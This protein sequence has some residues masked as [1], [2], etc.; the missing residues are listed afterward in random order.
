MPPLSSHNRF[1]TLSVDNIPKIDEPVADPQAVQ[2]L[3]KTPVR[4]P[5]RRPWWERRL[6]AHFIVDELDET[7]GPRRSLKLNIE[8]QTTDT[9]ETR[10]VKALLDSGATGMFIDR[11]YVK[12]NC[13]PTWTLSSPIPVRNVDGTLN[14]AGSVTEVV[15]LVLRYW[16]H[17]EHA[18]FAVTS[19]GSQKVIM[20]HSWLQKHNPDID[21]STREVKMSR[22]SGSCCSSCLDEIHTEPKLHKLEARHIS[23][24]SEGGLPAL[25]EE[26]D[27]EE[28]PPEIEDGD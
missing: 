13:F 28:T 22:C 2:P 16:N 14:E 19:L 27:E 6:L 5:T 4:V 25:V 21:W 8:L 9:G 24:C 1:S 15:E 7:E 10:A 11:A 3:E 17:L 23:Y 12:A 26:E 20:G 18:F